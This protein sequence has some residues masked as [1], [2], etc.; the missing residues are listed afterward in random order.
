MVKACEEKHGKNC[1]NW[2]H[3]GQW[4]IGDL[5]S[6]L[7]PIMNSGAMCPANL[8]AID[9]SPGISNKLWNQWSQYWNL[10][11]PILVEKSPQSMLKIP[12]M[13]RF[14]GS[15]HKLRFLI[16]IKVSFDSSSFCRHIH[17]FTQFFYYIYQHPVTLNIA[18]VRNFEW[19]THLDRTSEKLHTERGNSPAEIAANVDHFIKMM[20]VDNTEWRFVDQSL[21]Y[22]INCN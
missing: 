7:F 9:E 11:L 18:T 14:F 6:E 8:T 15:K 22:R 17:F 4:L 16:V 21:I 12:L 13:H 3:E 2:N 20:T 10:S 19:L 1:D 5:R